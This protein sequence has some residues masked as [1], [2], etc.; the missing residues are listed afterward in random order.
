MA[1]RSRTASACKLETL[2][3]CNDAL[4]QIG[5]LE[6]DLGHI[7]GICDKQ[8]A[9]SK[10]RASELARGVIEKRDALVAHLELYYELCREA[11]ESD[12][13]TTTLTYGK[14]GRRRSTALKPAGTRT[15]KQVLEAVKA[16]NGGA[17]IRTK[18]EVDKEA[19]RKLSPEQLSAVGLQLEGDDVWFYEVDR[20]RLEVDREAGLREAS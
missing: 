18:E 15:W 19:L 5:L 12:G 10:A 13:K 17:F 11:L 16:R 9:R 3:D 14:M 6:V 4:R 8:V 7:E 2:D 20:V 1:T